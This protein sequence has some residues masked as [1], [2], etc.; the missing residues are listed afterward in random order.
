MSWL[1]ISELL[2]GKPA[3]NRIQDHQRLILPCRKTDGAGGQKSI[4][5]SGT[6]EK[7]LVSSSRDEFVASILVECER[8]G[9]RLNSCNA[10]PRGH[11][12][13]IGRPH[14]RGIKHAEIAVPRSDGCSSIGKGHGLNARR[15]AGEDQRLIR[16]SRDG[17]RPV[18][19]RRR[20]ADRNI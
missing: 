20:A 14:A 1:L 13:N 12:V 9:G 2:I 3:G 11:N 17:D 16:T 19:Y 4:G 18:K 15:R 10:R 5:R 7:Y 8:S 6:R